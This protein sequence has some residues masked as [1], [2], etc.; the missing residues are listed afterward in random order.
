MTQ[1]TIRADLC[2][3]GAGAAGLSVAAGA[4]RLGLDV[5]LFEAG[6]MGGECLNT[7]CVPSKALLAAA[8]RAQAI[9]EADRFGVSA[10]EPRIDFPAVMAHVR[11]AIAAI[12]P[13]DS[14][15]RFEGLGARVIRERARFVAGD[16]VA[17][18]SWRVAARRFVLATGADPWVPPVEGIG[19][20]PY[21]TNETLF[22]LESRPRHLAILG[23]GPSGVEMA[24]AFRRLGAQVT[25]IEP[26][27]PLGGADP[28]HAA[29]LVGAL[30]REG[31]AVLAGT[32][33][34]R[35]EAAEDGVRIQCAGAREETVAASHL[36]VAAGRRVR[37]AGLGLD[38]AGIETGSGR[39]VL[40]SRLRTTN[41]RVFA[42]G[43][44]AGLDML[45]HA[46]GWHASVLIG[47]LY[48]AQR[49]RAADALIPRAVYAEPE[50]AWAGLSEGEARARHG[51]EVR[52]AEW[53]F[54]D[55][56]RAVAEAAEA[57]GVKLV[58]GR[59][60]KI[61]GASILGEGAA[62]LLQTI[63]GVI[64]AGGGMRQLTEIVPAYP[65]RGEAVKRAAGA[66]YEDVVFGPWAR[67]LARI[68]TLFQ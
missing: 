40:D 55:N 19:S 43:D 48:F 7:G 21:L 11:G 56:D 31:V 58:A 66:Y 28:E 4:A 8:R 62:D 18:D 57:G 51:R 26:A 52:I 25:L 46:A 50:L 47:N 35:V 65:T 17:S 10:G 6:E 30:E 23:A 3:I 41:R 9:R 27:R 42:A 34:R 68:L 61:L 13:N 44:A 14:Q 12:A 54:A 22:G 64:A 39:L 29:A 45:T 67:R 60:G 59:G 37:T 20:V 63:Q 16:A 15:E 36:F 24:Q 2:V 53:P 32:E 1:K 5:V 49:T 38:A 33:A